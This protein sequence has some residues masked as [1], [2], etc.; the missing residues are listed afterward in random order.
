MAEYVN[1]AIEADSTEIEDEVY[2]YIQGVF[3]DWEPREPHLAVVLTEALAS[4]IA[5]TR[6]MASDV[7][8]TIFRY[9]GRLVGITPK[10]AVSAT[11]TATLTVRNTVGHTFQAD[12]LTFRIHVSGDEYVGF[13]NAE[14][15]IIP[16]GSDSTSFLIE[17]LN[18]GAEPN[19]LTG[20]LEFITV[21]DRVTGVVLNGAIAGGQSEEDEDTFLDRLSDRLQLLADRP[22]LPR[23]FEIYVRSMFP[24]VDRVLAL[25]LFNPADSTYNNERMLTVVPIDAAGAAMTSLHSAIVAA[26]DAVR[27]VNFIVNV[28]APT[29]TPMT[30]TATVKAYAGFNTAEVEANVEAAVAQYL[31]PAR[32]G[33]PA[34][35][36]ERRWVKDGWEKVRFP[37]IMTVINNVE[38][39]NYIVNDQVVLNGLAA[40][41]NVMLTGEAP[42]PA[43][44]PTI[45]I[46]VQAA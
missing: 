37:E 46:T 36:E 20:P 29:Y 34:H 31:D 22:I 39:V 13:T 41:T 27:E 30:V 32:W 38:G 43:P 1:P 8:P 15:V 23:D 33:Q 9:F 14:P 17:A 7:P 10:E 18:D 26:L 6:E 11:G 44:N 42:L 28:M 19:G 24:T 35:G 2:E 16:S 45:N 25:D 3:P 4:V 40:N 5:D 12:E 21:D